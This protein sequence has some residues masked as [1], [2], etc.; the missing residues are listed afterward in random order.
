[1]DGQSI[2]RA[3]VVLHP[4]TGGGLFYSCAEY[5]SRLSGLGPQAQLFHPQNKAEL[6]DG[7]FDGLTSPSCINIF[8]QNCP[9]GYDR[10]YS[11]EFPGFNSGNVRILEN[12][13]HDVTNSD[14]ATVLLFDTRDQEGDAIQKKRVPLLEDQPISFQS[15]STDSSQCLFNPGMIQ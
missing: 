7:T 3:L 12:E 14:L 11:G 5:L 10:L 4:R 9:G 15:R 13:E 6:S 1:M 8:Q 2:R